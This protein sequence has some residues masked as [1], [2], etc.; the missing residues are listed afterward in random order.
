MSFI[1]FY[2]LIVDGDHGGYLGG[3]I[4]GMESEAGKGGQMRRG[5][6]WTHI[7][8]WWENVILC[9]EFKKRYANVTIKD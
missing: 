2:H 5:G 4:D 7:C 9:E 3:V 8:L 6:S 1:H